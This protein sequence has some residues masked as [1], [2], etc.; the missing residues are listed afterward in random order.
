[1]IVGSSLYSAARSETLCAVG[2]DPAA[3]EDELRSELKRQ[4]GLSLG[5]S[6]PHAPCGAMVVEVDTAANVAVAAAAAVSVGDLITAVNGVALTDMDAVQAALLSATSKSGAPVHVQ[7]AVRSPASLES[8]YEVQAVLGRGKQGFVARAVTKSDGKEVAVKT[9]STARPCFKGLSLSSAMVSELA[10]YQDELLRRE[11]DLLRLASLHPNACGLLHTFESPGRLQLVMELCRGGDLQQVLEHRGALSEA[12]VANVARQLCEVVA[13]IHSRNAI[14]RDIKPAN[15]MIADGP[16]A[17]HFLAD[18]SLQHPTR[19]K[20][21]DF[22]IG[23]GVQ[24]KKTRRLLPSPKLKHLRRLVPGSPVKSRWSQSREWSDSNHQRDSSSGA[25]VRTS[26]FGVSRHSTTT[27]STDPSHCSVSHRTSRHLSPEGGPLRVATPPQSEADVATPSTAVVP[28]DA[29]TGKES[30]FGALGAFSRDPSPSKRVLF[31]DLADTTSTPDPHG[32][33]VRASG[34]LK[35]GR[36][37]P[38]ESDTSSPP[39]PELIEMSIVGSPLYKAPELKT[40]GSSVMVTPLQAMAFDIYSLGRTLLHML[41]GYPPGHAVYRAVECG[42]ELREELERDS[43][44]KSRAGCCAAFG[45]YNPE[46]ADDS[47]RAGGRRTVQLGKLSV[48]ACD[49]LATLT[50]ADPEM[51]PTADAC[52]QLPFVA[53]AAGSCASGTDGRDGREMALAE[54]DL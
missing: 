29:A 53:E 18:G 41:T 26:S 15:V 10:A 13:F 33:D 24:P 48:D 45:C 35:P 39:S 51:R 49:M 12:E 42:R 8:A 23:R 5:P 4:F 52:L 11:V 44:R 40:R 54:V 30:S 27:I 16:D 7:V 43:K 31:W 22:G 17:A 47:E 3:G 20:L 37:L 38:C 50:R 1:M 19:V 14:H 2:G 9:V 6:T 34:S 25:P 28:A 36:R 32:L 21:V 46:P